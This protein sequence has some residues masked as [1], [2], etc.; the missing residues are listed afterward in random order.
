MKGKED[1]RNCLLRYDNYVI[2]M[3]EKGGALC[4]ELFQ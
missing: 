2:I 4:L 1:Y 3:G